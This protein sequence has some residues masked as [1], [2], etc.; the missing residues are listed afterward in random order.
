MKLQNVSDEAIRRS[1][2]ISTLIHAYR[3]LDNQAMRH[4]VPEQADRRATVRAAMRIITDAKE[5]L[6]AE[7]ESMRPA[8]VKF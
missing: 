3:H 6:Y 8:G 7:C 1:A 5:K 4:R 2:A